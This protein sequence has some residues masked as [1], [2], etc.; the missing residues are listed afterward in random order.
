LTSPW[1]SSADDTPPR[2]EIPKVRPHRFSWK[3]AGTIGIPKDAWHVVPQ[4]WVENDDGGSTEHAEVIT[5]PSDESLFQSLHG[6][7]AKDADYDV[8]ATS[9]RSDEYAGILDVLREM[10]AQHPAAMWFVRSWSA[11]SAASD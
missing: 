10:A 1:D 11:D 5:A 4:R 6:V 7:T 2:L 9:I 3:G 8:L